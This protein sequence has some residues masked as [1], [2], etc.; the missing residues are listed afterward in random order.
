MENYTYF[1]TITDSI[2]MPGIL[3][4]VLEV[5]FQITWQEEVWRNPERKAAGV[6]RR[7]FL[8]QKQK[9]EFTATRYS[10]NCT[11][12]M[13]ASKSAFHILSRTPDLK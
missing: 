4:S 13:S 9:E 7:V 11:K 12:E 6:G 5:Q 8:Y 3:F 1:Y 10:E 2:P